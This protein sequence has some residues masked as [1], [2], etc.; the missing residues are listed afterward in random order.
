MTTDK[1]NGQ[2]FNEGTWKECVPI[3]CSG[4]MEGLHEEKHKK[5]LIYCC[6]CIVLFLN[7]GDPLTG[8]I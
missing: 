7:S 4:L 1:Q 5:G 3:L 6:N 2:E 8:S